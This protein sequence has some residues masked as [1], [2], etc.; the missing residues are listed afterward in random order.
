MNWPDDYVN[1]IVQGD[2][3]E[4][5]K[6]IPNESIDMIFADVPYGT[7]D[8]GFDTEIPIK[9][10]WAQFKRVIKRNRAI[11]LTASQPFTSKLVVS[12]GDWFKCEWIWEKNAGSNFGT[13][14]WYP[15]KEHESVLVFARGT[16]L[17]NP[18]MEERAESGKSRV[19]TPVKFNTTG[20]ESYG[21]LAG[22][23]QT[24]VQRGELRVPRS[25]QRFNRERGLHPSQKPTDLLEYFLRTYSNEGDLV[26]DCTIGSGTTAV[27]AINTNRRFIG[28]ELDAKYCEIARKRV[29]DARLALDNIA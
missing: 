23:N 28:I 19:K 24:A 25:I 29:D 22:A 1:Q 3:L 14:K 13:T 16:P 20:S 10:L 18:I 6:E 8:A 12:G 26:L 11:V 9:A 5:M 15:M 2:C 4:V 21:G 17:Y 7:T 27:A